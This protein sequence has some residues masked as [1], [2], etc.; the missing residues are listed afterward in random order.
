MKIDSVKIQQSA[1]V[2]NSDSQTSRSQVR[3]HYT[4]AT[5]SANCG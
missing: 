4:V 2:E 5:V 1:A 3:G